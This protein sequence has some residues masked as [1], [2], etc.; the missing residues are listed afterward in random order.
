MATV[1]SGFI[2]TSSVVLRRSFQLERLHEYAVPRRSSQQFCH[3]RLERVCSW[4]CVLLLCRSCRQIHSSVHPP[5]PVSCYAEVSNLSICTNTQ[6]LAEAHSSF[7]TAGL[8]MCAPGCVSF[9]SVAPIIKSI[10]L[11]S[12]PTSSVVL[13]RSFQLEHLHEYV[14]PC[15]SSQQCDCVA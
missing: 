9:C 11:G 13:R 3:C 6:C 8:S 12:P 15:R 5:L 1:K 4:L 10:A 2:P 14:V 7:V